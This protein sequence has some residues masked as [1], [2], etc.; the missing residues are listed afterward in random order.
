MS[1]SHRN[2]NGKD[3]PY[4]FKGLS[5][6]PQFTWKI[7]QS[8]LIYN[9]IIILIP[10]ILSKLKHD[11]PKPNLLFKYCNNCCCYYALIHGSKIS[12]KTRALKSYKK[13]RLDQ[14]Y[15]PKYDII[16]Y[17]YDNFWIIILIPLLLIFIIGFVMN[18]PDI[19]C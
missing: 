11:D 16:L 18:F 13:I 19:H 4:Q 6:N 17:L 8:N 10:D 12:Y 5:W 9:N 14:I 1:I 3:N 15:D 7:I 2:C